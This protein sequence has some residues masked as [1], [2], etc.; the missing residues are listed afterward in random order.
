M[1]PLAE[2]S[3]DAA[4]RVKAVLTDIDDTLTEHGRL[5]AIAYDALERLKTAGLIVVPV[6][7]RPAGWCALLC[8]GA[9]SCYQPSRL[10]RLRLA[11][12]QT[13]WRAAAAR[14]ACSHSAVEL[15]TPGVRP[16][17]STIDV[18]CH[19]PFVAA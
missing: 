9:Q 13:A 8:A 7:G 11:S 15:E 3:Q 12:K 16:I 1:R 6:T 10:R 18:V 17:E 2:F 5:P 4:R 14:R 19:G